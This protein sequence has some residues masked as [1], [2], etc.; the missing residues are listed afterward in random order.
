M[1]PGGAPPSGWGSTGGAQEAMHV[2]ALVHICRGIFRTP[3]GASRGRLQVDWQTYHWKAVR[4]CFATLAEEGS[5]KDEVSCRVSSTMPGRRVP[6]H[7][8]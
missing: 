6:R 5:R 7:R 3:Q 4:A 1:Q 2:D 8:A